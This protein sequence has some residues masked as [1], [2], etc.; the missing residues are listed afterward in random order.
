MEALAEFDLTGRTAIV[1]GGNGGIGKGI[2]TGLARAGANV[3]IAARDEAKSAVALDEFRSAGYR[4]ATVRCDVSVDGDAERAVRV[5]VE[6]FGGLSILV[7]NAASFDE[8][9][10]SQ[11][12][13]AWDGMFRT[14]V[15][16]P[17]VFALAARDAMK[18]AGSGKIINISS[19]ASTIAFPGLPGYGASK[20]ALDHLTRSLALA[21]APYN[22][23][24]NSLL[25]GAFRTP[26]NRFEGPAEEAW[27]KLTPAKRIG[28]A[29]EFAG[30]AIFL[31]SR[32]SDYMTGQVFAFDGGVTIPAL[33][34]K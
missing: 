24:V 34:P 21:F 17:Y 23:Q 2:A 16:G 20:S 7:N 22:I 28:D 25:P 15:R 10:G 11:A 14:N 13:D 18:A 30:V 31:A 32:A 19:G 5:A 27:I 3:V 9:V 12:I 6:T 26:T 33:G 4:A 29:S 1:T 8:S